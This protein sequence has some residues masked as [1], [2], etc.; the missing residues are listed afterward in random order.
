MASDDAILLAGEA[1]D[2]AKQSVLVSLRFLNSACA[3]LS[4]D[5]SEGSPVLTDGRR[6][7]F[8]PTWALKVYRED[9]SELARAYL[10]MVLH[11]VFLHTYPAEGT[12]PQA[13]DA[14]CDIVVEQT[15]DEL[16]VAQLAAS[17]RSSRQHAALAEA[18]I[19][20]D[21]LTAESVYAALIEAGLQPAELDALRTPFVVDEHAHWHALL[22]EGELQQ[23]DAKTGSASEEEDRTAPQGKKPGANGTD[24]DIPED[25]M[26]SE[27]KHAAEQGM[28][29]DDIVRKEAPEDARIAQQ[30]RMANT[31]NLDRSREQWE[32]A[33]LEVGVAMDGYVHLYGTQGS[34]LSMNLR[35]VTRKKRDYRDFLRKFSRMAEH[36]R[37]NDDEFDYVHYCYGLAHYGNLPLIEPLEYAEEN[38]VRSFCIAIDT[39]ASTKDGLVRRFLEETYAILG[40]TATFAADADIM[41]VQC[42]AAITDV[43][44]IHGQRDF[45]RYL[46]NL[47]IKGLGGTDFRPVFAYLDD[48]IDRRELTN[49]QG[50]LYLTDGFGTYPS[51]PPAY[52]SAFVF[53]DDEAAD[54]ADTPP[55]AIKAA[56]GARVNVTDA[57]ATGQR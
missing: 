5:P 34:L 27:P 40:N 44:H 56:L 11:N 19:R 4:L 48:L 49:L 1:M 38:R 24:M 14:A 21:H 9:P 22:A 28:D 18:D 41:I 13:W 17:A 57:R 39:S 25:A 26:P 32:H 45:D 7:R 36:I 2:A 15:I 16:G 46:D 43:T 6:I 54:A 47:E 23:S 29:A 33:A 50:L 51:T 31:V 53:A 37:I 55:W 42:D 20:Y 35:N 52:R 10:H 12:D 8:D 3:L 30:G